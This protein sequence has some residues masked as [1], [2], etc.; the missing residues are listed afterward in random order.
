MSNLAH[1]WGKGAKDA[2][3]LGTHS[4]GVAP[5]TAKTCGGRVITLGDCSSQ[6]S[7]DKVWAGRGCLHSHFPHAF[8]YRSGACSTSR[9]CLPGK[10]ILL[11]TH[12]RLSHWG[13]PQVMI[14]GALSSLREERPSWG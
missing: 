1:L 4:A 7:E 13:L 6:K 11:L 8:S 14:L 12:P 5:S 2:R 10:T 3:Y 9:S